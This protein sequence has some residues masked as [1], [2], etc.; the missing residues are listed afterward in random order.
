MSDLIFVGRA[1]IEGE[2]KTAAVAIKNG[3]I[4]EVSAGTSGREG[5]VITLAANQILLPSAVDMLAAARDWSEAHRD[6]VET[7]TKAALAGGITVLCDQ[8]NTIPRINTAQMVER[9]VRTFA[10]QSYVDFGIQSHPPHEDPSLASKLREAGAFG[11]TF[12]QWDML[13]WNTPFDVDHTK[14]RM[15]RYAASGLHGMAFVEELAMRETTLEDEAEHWAVNHLLRRLHPDFP[16]RVVV[17]L[18][19][20]VRK[21]HAAKPDFPNLRLQIAPHYL[22]MSREVAYERIG[23]AAGHSPPLRSAENVSELRALAAEGVFDVFASQHAPHRT[24]DKHNSD[25][26]P[27]ELKPKRGFTSL[28]IAYPVLLDKIGLAQTCK[29]FCETPSRL[30]GLKQGKIGVGYDADLV[31]IEEGRWPVDPDMFESKGK[32]TPFVGEKLKYRIGK[33]FLRGVE[34]F[35]ALTRAFTRTPVRHIR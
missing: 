35:D 17:T 25:P 29:S 21:L 12:F 28:D 8:P 14:E 10:E 4:H 11:L 33:T 16:L 32:V 34:V 15:G 2:I 23:C 22:C 9:R 24:P 18:A 1:L 13:P 30:L 31:I 6:T 5:P 20:S 26:E 19:E 3:V 27:G 7:A